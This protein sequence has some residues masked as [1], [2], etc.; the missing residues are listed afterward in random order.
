M[1]EEIIKMAREA[2]AMFEELPLMDGIVFSVDD[3]E[4]N[5]QA[6][7][8]EEHTSELQSH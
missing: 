1:N 2:G 6:L 3:R 7:R 8:S 5:S 4:W